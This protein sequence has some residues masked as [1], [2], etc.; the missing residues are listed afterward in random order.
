M[1]EEK[2]FF[3]DRGVKVTNS[4]FITYGKTHSLSGI[5][6]VSSQYISPSR[7][8]P[9]I[10]G[11]IGLAL[12]AWKWFLALIVIALA[13]GWWMSQKTIYQVVLAS[14]SGENDALSDKD[15]D[16]IN[17]VVEALNDAIVFRG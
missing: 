8:W 2:V 14:S 4:R 15:Q 12:F 13:V 11:V 5:T 3:E 16:F 1:A 9:I 6:A 10:L 17:K 7:K